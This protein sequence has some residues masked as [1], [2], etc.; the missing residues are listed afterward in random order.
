M[1]AAEF[2]RLHS[3]PAFRL[4][5]FMDSDEDQYRAYVS[6]VVEA[7]RIAAASA[8]A[9][10]YWGDDSTYS[11]WMPEV[12]RL[13]RTRDLSGTIRLIQLPLVAASVIFYTAGVA[14]V[15]SQ[16]FAA[17]AK[18]LQLRGI[19]ATR[20]PKAASQLLAASSVLERDLVTA[21]HV[22][23]MSLGR[24][25]LGLGEPAIDEALQ[26]F[27]ILRLCMNVLADERFPATVD[28]YEQASQKIKSVEKLDPATQTKAWNDRDR[29]VGTVAG[30]CRADGAH[31]LASERTFV[32]EENRSKWCS[33]VAER[34][35]EDVKRVGDVH[36]LSGA[37]SAQPAELWLALK[38]VSVAVARVGH[39]LQ[40]A[41]TPVG[42]AAFVPSEFWLDTGRPP[43]SEQS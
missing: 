19:K 10:A 38:G 17:L 9:L 30:F 29:V 21:H 24:E 33:P 23:V 26:T 6:Q 41:A 8:A 34:L 15:A 14:C 7:S 36:P 2:A 12:Q 11:W 1:L 5:R 43:A 18:L 25:A 27:E 39:Q 31:L 4:D 16:R 42:Y 3:Q 20:E 37:W 32:P 40:V 13:A 35:A 22:E 28:E